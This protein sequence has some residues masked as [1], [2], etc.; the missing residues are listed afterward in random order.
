M[1]VRLDA[2][3]RRRI[4][5]FLARWPL[6]QS[7]RGRRE[8]LGYADLANVASQ[9]DIE[10]PP[11]VAATELVRTLEVFGRVTYEHEALGQFLSTVKELL[12][13]ADPSVHLFED[14]LR[15]YMLLVPTAGLPGID[16]WRGDDALTQEKII[17]ENTLRH[18]AFVELAAHRA[19][20]VA[21]VDVGEWVGTGF[22]IARS[23]LLTNDHVVPEAALL[24]R[25]RGIF[26]YQLT[27]DGAPAKTRSYAARP[28]G[29]YLHDKR[30]DFAIVELAEPAGDEW[31]V[32]PVSLVP[33]VRDA[34][35]N[36]IQHPAGMPKQISFQSNRVAYVDS[37]V[38]QYLTATLNGS[39]GS[40]V[41]DDDWNAVALH[42]SGG[43]LV[44]PASGRKYFRNE[45]V[46][47]SALMSSW[48]DTV[49][50]QLA[51]AGP[52]REHVV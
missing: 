39:S 37:T 30:L 13:G 16:Q 28:N 32:V 45:G 25:V 19:R 8:L 6:F 1:A 14:V 17:G 31:G 15:K 43:M 27:R 7:S 51:V 5:D 44:E 40:P 24:D 34:R 4:V 29:V 20:A 22:L 42:H 11:L 26:N 38:T 3:D 2:A 48:P 21:L 10:G 52:S 47:L 41:F 23:L 36:I 33:P 35:V 12:G 46:L 49:T 18:I 50:E 9:V